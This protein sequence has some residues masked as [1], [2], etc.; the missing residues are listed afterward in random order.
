MIL[1]D[2]NIISESMRVEPDARVIDWMDRQRASHLFLSAI[3]VDE[4]VFGIEILPDGRRKNHLARTFSAIADAFDGRIADFD[5][6]AARESAKLRAHRRLI[7]RP[8]SLADAQIAGI[9]KSKGLSLATLNAP[10]FEATDL[11]VVEPY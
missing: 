5:A 10:D 1:L 2:T 7:G 3:S 6:N 9:A 4:I 8:I 11:S